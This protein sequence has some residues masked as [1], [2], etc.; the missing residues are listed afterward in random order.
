MG[1]LEAT[2]VAVLFGAQ[3]SVV[4]GGLLCLVGVAAVARIFPELWRHMMAAP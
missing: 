3:F 4:S 2:G 1:D